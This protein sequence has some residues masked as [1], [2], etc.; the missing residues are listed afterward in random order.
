MESKKTTIELTEADLNLLTY[1]LG[2]AAGLVQQDNPQLFLQLL[3]LADV[4]H[5]NNPNWTP[6]Q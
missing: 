3:T 5:A 2:I 6:S 4:V 1:A